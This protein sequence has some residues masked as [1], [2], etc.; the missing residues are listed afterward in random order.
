MEDWS[1]YNYGFGTQ[2]EYLE[3]T[4]N[5][6]GYVS[7][8]SPIYINLSYNGYDIKGYYP[9][10]LGSNYAGYDEESYARFGNDGEI[11][12]FTIVPYWYSAE[13]KIDWGTGYYW[14]YL[15]CV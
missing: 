2:T 5:K 7:W 3:F 14:L 15:R 10:Q 1:S 4:L 8:E 11:E 9:S 13:A 12:L 6:D